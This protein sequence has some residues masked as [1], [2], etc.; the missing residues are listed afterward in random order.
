LKSFA[1]SEK[2]FTFAEVTALLLSW[3]DPTLFFGSLSA[4]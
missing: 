3:I 4:A 2:F 1:S